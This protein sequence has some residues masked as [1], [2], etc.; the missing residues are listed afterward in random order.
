M[1]PHLSGVQMEQIPDVSINTIRE[2]MNETKIKITSN[3]ELLTIW[4]KTNEEMKDMNVS[5]GNEYFKQ[6]FN[7]LYKLLIQDI[8]KA[9]L[10]RKIVLNALNSNTQNNKQLIDLNLHLMN[11]EYDII[12]QNELAFEQ[13]LP[14]KNL[15]TIDTWSKQ[16]EKCNSVV[17]PFIARKGIITNHIGTLRSKGFQTIISIKSSLAFDPAGNK[18]QYFTMNY[19]HLDLNCNEKK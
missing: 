1:A 8:K 2:W 6:K 7:Q 10:Y 11:L 9:Q 18:I 13:F 4:N 12:S 17:E 5:K 14:Q 16:E 19:S 15:Y 3:N